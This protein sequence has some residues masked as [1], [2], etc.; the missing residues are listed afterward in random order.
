MERHKNWWEEKKKCVV[1]IS[2]DASS[3]L[4]ILMYTGTSNRSLRAKIEEDAYASGEK[5]R[6]TFPSRNIYTV[7]C[8]WWTFF[9]FVCKLILNRGRGGIYIFFFLFLPNDDGTYLLAYFGR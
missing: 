4:E 7:L 3:E 2:P 9:H 1:R 5:V 8:T 6:N